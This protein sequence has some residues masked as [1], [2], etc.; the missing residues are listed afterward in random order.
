[1]WDRANRS[2]Q[3]ARPRP[4]LNTTRAWQER[5]APSL[6]ARRQQ[7]RPPRRARRR[8]VQRFAHVGLSWGGGMIGMRVAVLAPARVAALALLDTSAAPEG[9]RNRIHYRVM[10]STY[11]RVGIPS[12]SRTRGSS[13]GFSPRRRAPRASRPRASL[14]GRCGWLLAR[15]G[16]PRREGHLPTQDFRKELGRVRAPTLVVCGSGPPTRRSPP[17]NR[18]G[19][20]GRRADD[21]RGRASVGGRAARGRERGARAVPPACLI[22]PRS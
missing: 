1:M 9:I 8:R 19:G 14:L 18:P 3:R 17:R 15:G 2:A 7:P 20:L 4:R 11:R 12:G 5:A 22:P 10:L 16:L 6:L 13:R 21:R